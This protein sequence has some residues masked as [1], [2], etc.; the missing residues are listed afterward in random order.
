MSG[1]WGVNRTASVG[2]K[3]KQHWGKLILE[4]VNDRGRERETEETVLV[5]VLV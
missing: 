3:W 2:Q 4:P 1:V 5:V